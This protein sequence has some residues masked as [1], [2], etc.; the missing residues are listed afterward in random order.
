MTAD[1]L[2]V[3]DVAYVEA[4]TPVPVPTTLLLMG[5]CLVGL[6]GARRNKKA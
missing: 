1:P 6:A 2:Y 3:D 4:P 5:S